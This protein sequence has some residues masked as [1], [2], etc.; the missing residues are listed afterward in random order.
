MKNIYREFQC[1]F[2]DINLLSK[3]KGLYYFHNYGNWG[4]SVI[5]QGFLDFAD[6]YGLGYRNYIRRGLKRRRTRLGQIQ[7]KILSE[8]HRF[9][10]VLIYG[11]GGGWCRNWN[12]SISEVEYASRAFNK[13]IVLPSTYEF[14]PSRKYDNVVFYARDRFESQRVVSDSKFCHDMAFFLERRIS[15]MNILKDRSDGFFFREDKESLGC[16]NIPSGNRDISSEGNQD[17]P[18][19]KFLMEI[20]RYKN[21]HTDRLHVAICGAMLGCYVNMYPGNYRKNE[22]LFNSTLSIYFDNVR[23]LK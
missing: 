21:I 12:T 1:L 11:G 4:D 13:V 22:D 18:I 8:Y 23:F 7:N 15:R 17:T 10:S 14:P 3:G 6:F 20:G 5:R 9:A 19:D 16:F 2:D